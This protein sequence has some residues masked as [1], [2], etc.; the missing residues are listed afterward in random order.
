MFLNT[1]NNKSIGK[2][3]EANNKI[4]EK[5]KEIVDLCTKVVVERED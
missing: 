3:C 2:T 4:K 5:E 1:Y